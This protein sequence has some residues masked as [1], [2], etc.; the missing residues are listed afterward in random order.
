[1]EMFRSGRRPRDKSEQ[2]IFNNLQG[3]EYIRTLQGE[4]LTPELV[5][6]IHARMM[7]GT[8]NDEDLGRMQTSG[9]ERVQVVSNTDQTVLHTPPPADQLPTRISAMCD[10]ANA[11]G[12]A[13][14]LHPVIRAIALHLWLAYDHPFEDGNGRTARA[15]FYWS[16]LN[17]GYWMFEFISISSILRSASGQYARA[18]LHTETDENDA[19]YFIVYQLQVIRTALHALERYLEK[20]THEIQQAEKMLGDVHELN[21]RQMALL[22]HALRKPRADFTI[23]S[24]KVSHRV[25]YATARADL[26]ELVERGLLSRRTMGNALHFSAGQT[27]REMRAQ[28][29]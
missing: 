16:M 7:Q 25:A 3:M 12:E 27:L 20:K 17:A 23:H 18:Y 21:Y 5:C 29:E 1:M 6:A 14:F 24:H 10:F 9:D 8:I 28:A 2:M 22:S 11:V 26:L 19:T 4:A 13:E 15:L